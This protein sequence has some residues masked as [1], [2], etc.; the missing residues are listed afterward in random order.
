MSK[1]VR[2]R[3][4]QLILPMLTYLIVFYVT[5][6]LLLL[7]TGGQFGK[8]LCILGATVVTTPVLYDYYR[9][10]PIVRGKRESDKKKT[11]LTVLM[12]FGI[13]IVG[14]LFNYVVY[15]YGLLPENAAFEASKK[16]VFDGNIALI[17]LTDCIAVP[18]MEE[19][20]YRGIIL[21]QLSLWFKEKKAAAVILSSFF[22][23]MLHFNIIQFSYAMCMGIMIGA[24]YI[25][26]KR[27]VPVIAAHGLCNLFVVVMGLAVG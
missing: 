10:I 7:V 23:G 12:I 1:E 18:I 17:I 27:L 5:D 2:N 20:L 26:T 22:F 8:L 21:G 9:R 4:F 15:S 25:R 14:L 19:L 3:V 24:L 6:A 11:A 16:A 13:A